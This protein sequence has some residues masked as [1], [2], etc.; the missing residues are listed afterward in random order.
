M[1]RAE[2]VVLALGAPGE[3]RQPAGLAERPDPVAPAG[4][5]LVRIGLVA[6][7][8]DQPVVRRVED[9]VERHRQ[10]DHAEPGAE[11][12]AGDRDRGDR[13]L[14]E[15]VGHLSELQFVELPEVGRQADGVEE[16]RRRL[17]HR[18]GAARRNRK[19]RPA[20]LAARNGLYQLEIGAK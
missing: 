7:V 20:R 15:L 18:M 3:A 9:V 8:P 5:D 12:A 11:M 4:E 13:L 16:R 19:D 17:R 6:D 2:G 14:A 10:L 1:R